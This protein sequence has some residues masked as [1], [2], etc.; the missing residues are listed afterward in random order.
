MCNH[1]DSTV[2]LLL[3][4][5][6]LTAVAGGCG[7]KKEALPDAPGAVVMSQQENEDWEIALV[8]MR[9]G[10]NEEFADPTR[11]PLPP[12]ALQDFQGLNYYYPEPGLR[13]RTPLI[14]AAGADTILLAKRKG[15][16][17]PYLRRGLVRFRYRD[18]NHELSVFGPVDTTGG[19]YLWLP[20]YDL[21]NGKHTYAGGRYLDLKVDGDGMVDLDF[22]YAYNP[23]CDYN[24]DQFNCTLPPPENTLPFAVEAGEQTFGS[25]H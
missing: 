23:L 3:S 21:T 10:K 25:A 16:Q 12:E 15:Q 22:N 5:V 14:A 11:T 24:P 7:P 4:V 18:Q 2:S 19:D 13:F 17:V 20:F 6:F 8:E 1:R 9:I